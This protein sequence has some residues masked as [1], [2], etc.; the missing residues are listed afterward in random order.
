MVLLV[1]Q[2]DGIGL[3]LSLNFVEYRFKLI[4]LA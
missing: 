3:R 4:N 2:S 1:F